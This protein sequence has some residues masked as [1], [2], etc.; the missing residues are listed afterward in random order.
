MVYSIWWI[1]NPFSDIKQDFQVWSFRIK[2][3]F[4]CI[5]CK[6]K[7]SH[8]NTSLDMIVFALLMCNFRYIIFWQLL[9]LLFKDL[10][11]LSDLNVFILKTLQCSSFFYYDSLY[12]VWKHWVWQLR[13][14]INLFKMS[15]KF[16]YS[17]F[18]I[19]EYLITFLG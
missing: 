18:S 6:N 1:V 12:F 9:L 7:N 3:F 2:S 19:L 8:S 10:V 16:N 5:Q 15:Y 4:L 11:E 14:Y 13:C 17:G